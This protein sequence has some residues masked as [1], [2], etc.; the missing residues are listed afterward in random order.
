VA[1]GLTPVAVAPVSR[2]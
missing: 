2:V 1:R